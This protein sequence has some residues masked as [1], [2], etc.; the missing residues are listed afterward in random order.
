[1]YR[2]IPDERALIEETIIELVGK[3]Q[4][5]CSA[6]TLPE[7]RKLDITSTDPCSCFCAV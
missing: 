1:M 5:S 3:R 7:I 4:G 2:V 6:K